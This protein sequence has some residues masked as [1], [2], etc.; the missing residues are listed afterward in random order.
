MDKL[1]SV[2]WGGGEYVVAVGALARDVVLYGPFYNDIVARTWARDTLST[3]ELDRARVITIKPPS[4]PRRQ[5]E[6]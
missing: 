5:D 4:K 1:E 3:E 6:S 2:F